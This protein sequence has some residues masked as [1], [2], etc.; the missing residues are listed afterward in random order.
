VPVGR[1]KRRKN[2]GKMRIVAIYVV[3][4]GVAFSA[5]S[6]GPPKPNEPTNDSATRCPKGEKQC[7]PDCNGE[8]NCVPKAKPVCPH[9]DCSERASATAPTDE[10]NPCGEGGKECGEDCNGNLV[11]VPSAKH[12]PNMPCPVERSRQPASES[13]SPQPQ[14]C[15]PSNEPCPASAASC[16]KGYCF[17]S[18]GKSYC[19]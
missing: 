12:C 16:C 13:A 18:N 9:Y 2:R 5:C 7:G 11:C 1:D 10:P 19:G 15:T 14:S 4:L 3:L 6:S 17:Q 8:Y